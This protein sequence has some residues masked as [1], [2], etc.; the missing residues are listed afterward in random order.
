V[1]VDT[2]GKDTPYLASV[3]LPT[4]LRSASTHYRLQNLDATEPRRMC[5]PRLCSTQRWS[6]QRLGVEWTDAYS[7]TFFLHYFLPTSLSTRA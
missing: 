3:D 7:T 4:R 2:E 5:V 1:V 6:I